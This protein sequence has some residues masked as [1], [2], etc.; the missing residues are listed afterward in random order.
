MTPQTA[1]ALTAGQLRDW[2]A[3]YRHLHAHPELSAAEF[4]TTDW[5][6]ARLQALGFTTHRVSPTGVAG[7]FENG[8][9]PV[10][11]F[12]ADIDGLPVVEQTGVEW[13]SVNGAMHA[14]GHD[15]HMVCALGAAEVFIA[16]TDAWSGTLE[17]IF[18]PAEEIV[19]GARTMIDAGL[20][21]AIPH[22]EIVFGQHVWPIAAGEIQLAPGAFFSTVDVYRVEVRGRGGHGAMPETTVDT[23]VLSAAIV[24]RLQTI[25]SREIGLHEKA[26]LTVGS[27]KAGSKE[28]VIPEVGELLIS[29]RSYD[30]GVR[31]RIQD[32]IARVVRG[33]AAASGAPEPV[34]TP[35]YRASSI[36][37]DP[38]ATM[39]LRRVFCAAFGDECVVAAPNPMTPSEDFGYLAAAIGAPSVFWVFGGY[40]PER[41][42][43]DEPLPT[44]HSPLFLPD[45][46]GSVRTGTQAAIAALWSRLGH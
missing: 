30:E 40:S 27:I 20:W 44:N 12:R 39:A 13:A 4:A 31:Q 7:V 37:N 26:V 6:T 2:L 22:A 32:A 46:E 35:M 14:C 8:D 21:D 42:A 25:V 41:V 16:N 10:V 45:P 11:A 43:S 19:L 17:I 36:V 38:D 3:D 23:V 33:E 29:T 18:Q 9:G 24:M 28:N 34:I 1:L 15:I 5:L